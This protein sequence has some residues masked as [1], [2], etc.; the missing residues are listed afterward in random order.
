MAT[1]GR[2]EFL[3]SLVVCCLLA[4][5]GG[6]VGSI[7][8]E[9]DMPTNDLPMEPLQLRLAVVE[10]P[11][12]GSVQVVDIGSDSFRLTGS[13]P[14][15]RVGNVLVRGGEEPFQKVVTEILSQSA[16][17]FEVRTRQAAVDEV[18]SKGTIHVPYD[19][20]APPLENPEPFDDTVDVSWGLGGTADATGSP[21]LSFTPLKLKKDRTDSNGRVSITGDVSL[22]P[23]IPGLGF[24]DFYFTESFDGRTQVRVLGGVTVSASLEVRGDAQ[25]SFQ[26]RSEDPKPVLKRP[27][28]LARII[29]KAGPVGIYLDLLT[30]EELS[31]TGSGTAIYRASYERDFFL[32][33]F[34]DQTSQFYMGRANTSQFTHGQLEVGMSGE[35]KL[36]PRIYATFFQARSQVRESAIPKV[37]IQTPVSIF[38][39]MGCKE[40]GLQIQAELGV[41]GDV[42]ID[43][44][45]LFKNENREFKKGIGPIRMNL[46]GDSGLESPLCGGDGLLL[47]QDDFESGPQPGWIGASRE[48]TPSGANVLGRYS[49]GGPGLQISNIGE[50]SELEIEFDLHIIHTWDGSSQFGPDIFE[51]RVDGASVFSNTFSNL[52][53]SPQTYPVP[54]SAAG[55]GAILFDQLG[56]PSIFEGFENSTY[57]IKLRVPHTAS[58]VRLD[59]LGGSALE[60]VSNESWAID[61]LKVFRKG[62]QE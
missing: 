21:R 42:G 43:F 54:G 29:T 59:F 40:D 9:G 10:L 7:T 52:Q 25:S 19:P 55:T 11:A 62:S 58:S 8:D 32:K 24:M 61:N 31:V 33:A 60:P 26:L 56:Y 2:S 6:V 17:V 34:S 3:L 35:F 44:G 4:G 51:V 12:D 36:I 38:T 5:C 15:L 1:K 22:R 45:S 28:L 53:G 27:L 48:R 39:E 13:I 57:K 41:S 20:A 47:F 49:R 18:F 14:P 37:F 50:H 16:G 23:A 30:Q 46:F